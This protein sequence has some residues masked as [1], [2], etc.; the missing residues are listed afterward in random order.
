M[1][2]LRRTFKSALSPPTRPTKPTSIPESDAGS[3]P[4]APHSFPSQYPAHVLVHTILLLVSLFL[5]PRTAVLKPAGPTRNLDKPQHPFLEPL[6]TRPAFTAAWAV[7]GSALVVGW[8]AGSIREWIREGKIGVGISER[9]RDSGQRAD[10]WNAGVF[11]FYASLAFCFMI[12]LFGAPIS[13][14]LPHTYLFALSLAILTTLTPAYALGPPSFPI[15]LPLLFNAKNTPHNASTTLMLN[16]TWVRLFAE[17]SPRSAVERAI[18]YPSIG[19][20]MGAWTGVIPIGLDWDR[21]WQAYPLTPLIGA[22]VGYAF[23]SLSAVASSFVV[24]L[25]AYDVENEAPAPGDA[26]TSIE[27]KKKGKKAKKPVKEA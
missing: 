18:V 13:T 25:A 10:M 22:F 24:Y 14:H 2:S 6:T 3:A 12:V 21:P 19:A 15:Q 27:K 4:T 16:N 20:L 26:P 8:W 23:G 9:M 11:T 5:L 1:A 7:L 17:R